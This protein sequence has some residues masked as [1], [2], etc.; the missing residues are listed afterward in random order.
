MPV[1]D[2]QASGVRYIHALATLNGKLYFL[3]NPPSTSHTEFWV[4]DPDGTSFPSHSNYNG[5]GLYGPLVPFNDRIVFT[6]IID[7]T[8]G[9]E[10]YQYDPLHSISMVEDIYPGI[11]GSSAHRLTVYENTLF[12]IADDGATG[13]ELYSWDGSSPVKRLTDILPGPD[14]SFYDTY[15]AGYNDKLY[16]SVLDAAPFSTAKRDIYIYNLMTGL[17]QKE[18]PLKS[19][20][21]ASNF[22]V[23]EGQ[24][25]FTSHS[26][27]HPGSFSFAHNNLVNLADV[28]AILGVTINNPK[29]ALGTM[30][31]SSP[32]NGGNFELHVLHKPFPVAV[33]EVADANSAA[34]YPN[35]ASSEAHISFAITQAAELNIQ[36]TD[37]LGR[38]VYTSMQQF[39]T[40]QL[41]IKIPV[42]QL[43]AGSYIYS[44]IN[45][46]G[47][48]VCRGKL[49]KD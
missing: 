1:A 11:Y 3:G 26:D 32:D 44:I 10:L 15:M 4:Y 19:N 43:A 41:E 9:T 8:K 28:G 25:Y 46:G 7:S 21:S 24:L 34:I 18:I 20:Y 6:A 42:Q 35:P 22:A 45:D 5:A 37:M 13:S 29:V 30:F 2:V 40:G 23:F 16:F 14:D 12:F 33:K 27:L 31:F 49:I 38:V 36:L 17:L 47:E 39:N 48:M